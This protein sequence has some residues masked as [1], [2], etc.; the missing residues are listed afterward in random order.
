MAARSGCRRVVAVGATV[1]LPLVA[2]SSWPATGAGASPAGRGGDA[3][4]PGRSEEAASRARALS[5]E[6]ES[7]ATGLLAGHT[8]DRATTRVRTLA[9]QRKADLVDLF[10]ADPASATGALLPDPVLAAL[11][12]YAGGLLER[13]A[14]QAGRLGVSHHHD[15]EGASDFQPTLTAA[16]QVLRISTNGTLPD[17]APGS[18]VTASGYQLGSSFLVYA[19]APGGAAPMTATSTPATTPLGE[20][21]VAVLLADFSNSPTSLDPQVARNAFEGSPGADVVS[22]YSE[23]SYGRASLRP[24]VL[25]PYTIADA[26]AGGGACPN[27]SAPTSHLMDAASPDL[28]Y[29][30]FRR[31]I[32]VFNCTGYGATTGVGETE[33]STPQ[34]PIE[35]AMIYMDARSLGDRQAYAHELSHTLGNYH[36]GLFVCQPV[37]FVPPTRFGEGCA[38]AE[39]GNEFDTLGATLQSPKAMPHLG[40]HHKR[41]AGW[42]EPANLQT[43]TATGTSTYRLEP[44]ETPTAGALALEIPRGNS[45]TSFTLEYRQPTG[46]DAWMDSAN[47]TYCGG[48]CTAT[49]GPI[50][51]LVQSQSAGGGG[52]DTQAIDTT[53]ASIPTST[54][55]PIADNRDGALLPGRTFTD[56]EFGITVTT[57]SADATGATV[58]VT[59]PAAA[60]CI[61]QTPTV[62]LTS[63]AAQSASAGQPATFVL[64]V[65]SNDSASCPGQLVRYSGGPLLGVTGTGTLGTFTGVASPDEL[66]VAPGASRAVAVTLVPDATVTAG[67]YTYS[68]TSSGG[69]GTLSADSLNTDVVRL[70][71]VTFTVTSPADTTAPAAPE[72]LGAQ[73]LGATTARLTWLPAS[74]NLGVV[75]YKI[76]RD[77]S[78]V[79]Y[80]A[81]TSLTDAMVPAGSSRTYSVQAF[82]RQGNSSPAATVTVT[83]PLR[84]DVTPPS[85][86]AILTAAATDR[87]LSLSWGPSRDATGVVSYTVWPFG[88]RFPAGTTT[89]TFSNLPTNTAHALRVEAVDGA[90][91]R[92]AAVTGGTLTVTTAR[93]GGVAPTLPTRLHS[94]SATTTEGIRLVWSPSSSPGGIAG[95]HV[96]RNGRRWATVPGTSYVDPTTDLY[97]GAG[98]QYSVVAFDGTGNLSPA[99]PF[100]QTV[101]PRSST[102]DSAPPAATGLTSPGEGAVLSGT[103]AVAT[104]P[105]DDVG[106]TSVELFLD[107]TYAGQ[108]ST[109]PYSWA[110]NTTWTH[111]GSHVL[112]A[113]AYDAAGNY[114]TAAL[115]TVQVANDATPPSAASGLVASATAS[116]V[117]LTWTAAL[118]NV[119][120]VGY[121]VHRND[122]GQSPA[123]G[124]SWTDP[125]VAAGASYTY[126]VVAHDAAG[127]A[128]ASSQP[129]SV[130]VPAPAPPPPVPT[131]GTISGV[132]TKASNGALLAGVKVVA[133]RNGA[134]TTVTTGP[135]GS[136]SMPNLAA[137]SYSVAY[138]AKGVKSQTRTTTVTGGQTT[139]LNVAL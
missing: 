47:V 87:S 42:F 110:W 33:L 80:S 12:P 30:Q 104:A 25:G 65:T 129:A 106:I 73:V 15:A 6:L 100:V 93:A 9:E 109:A 78:S 7:L 34:G 4:A 51:Q 112:Y 21:G 39:Y 13:K 133:T 102:T 50:L 11:E 40:P 74:D 90:G 130:T 86:P 64:T 18:T 111:D 37:S 75:G 82:D 131:V 5:D 98:Y 43:V 62:T 121:T 114:A 89:A 107:G 85:G 119:G 95:Y 61:R 77:D 81:T 3:R 101:A 55:Y 84:T 139:T 68:L 72:G 122:G 92:S 134:R 35:G 127:N 16:G 22:W 125:A 135:S 124:T 59:I 63:P 70:P 57:L 36:A 123:S 118:D 60:G 1:M 76:L 14:T 132:V 94:P 88:T 79:Y 66:T 2:A 17:I 19:D 137:G 26:A 99:T 24:T 71:N 41:N 27:L 23:V 44:Y 58:E 83:T 56:P 115:T 113:R 49:R 31:I 32:L 53:P 8:S 54:F 138:S 69:I 97:P 28:T 136:Y 20:M 46:F 117:N 45:G 29:A 91:N 48:R 96:Y 128:S 120:V 103:V 10:V 126:Y 38:S 67:S 105:S 116:Q 108:D 52:S